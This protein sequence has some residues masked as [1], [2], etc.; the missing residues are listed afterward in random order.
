MPQMMPLNWLFLF[1]FFIFIFILFNI[2]N[3]Y[4]YD[5]KTINNKKL[6]KNFKSNNL[7]WKW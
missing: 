6:T 7:N 4:I 2:F 3:Y 1:F 5:M